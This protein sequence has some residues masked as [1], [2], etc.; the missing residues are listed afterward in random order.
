MEPL[1]EALLLRVFIGESDKTDG[2]P[3]YESIVQAARKRD[4]AGVTVLRGFMGFGSKRR[5]HT[6]KVLRLSEDLPVV[7]E[8]VD[9]EDKIEVFLSDLNK[10]IGEGLVTLEKIRVKV[11]RQNSKRIDVKI[12]K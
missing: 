7:I 10:M 11:Y 8:I 12:P 9:A 1:S 5:V 3:L 2:R 6:S 4:I